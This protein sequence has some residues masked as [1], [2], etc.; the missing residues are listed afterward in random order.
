MSHVPFDSQRL[1]ELAHREYQLGHYDKAEQYCTRLW[2]NDKKNT[3]VLLL[4]SSI[5]FQC[6]RLDQSERFCQIAISENPGLAEAYSNLGNVLREKGRLSEALDKYRRAVHLKRDFIDGYINLASA[7]VQAQDIDGAIRAYLNAL[8][9][10]P[11]L[12]CVRNDLGNLLKNIGQLEEAKACYLKAIET[13]PTFAVAWSNLGCVFNCQ[14]EVW[15]AIH[16]FEKAV[17]L[18][19]TF[20]DAYVNLANVLKEAKIYDRAVTNYLRALQLAPTNAIIHANLACVYYEQQLLDL[21]VETYRRAIEI[22]P[23]F[24]DAYC[25]LANALKGLGKVQEA[26]EC[27]NKALELKPEHADSLNNLA[28]IKR[29][30]GQIDESMRLYWK[31]LEVY[32]DFAAAHSNLASVLQTQGRLQEAIKHY[33]DAIRIQ[34]TFADAFS[35]MGNALKEMGEVHGAMNCY[36]RA[37]HLNPAFA[38]AHSNLASIHKDSGNVTEAIQSYRTALRLRTDFPDAYCNLVHCQ[39]IIC[40]WTDY[41]ARMNKIVTTVQDQLDKGRIPSVH[42]HH[43]ML[44]PLTHTQRRLLSGKHAQLC[45]E[46]VMMLKHQTFSYEKALEFSPKKNFRLK[47]GLVS[48]DFCNHPTSHL[49]QSIPG[50]FDRRYFEVFCY[51]L[52]A[53]DGTTFRAKIEKEVENYVDLN[54][55]SCN[56]KA[57]NRIHEDGIHVLLNMNGY[58]KGARNEI[59]ALKPAPIQIMWLGYP[60][61]SGASY[62]DYIILDRT[63]APLEYVKQY[64]EKLAYM[65][66]TFFIGDH[67]QMFHHLRNKLSLSRPEDVEQAQ[68]S[69]ESYIRDNVAVYNHPD[70]D[71]LIPKVKSAI[72][73]EQETVS[74]NGENVKVPFYFLPLTPLD[75]IHGQLQVIQETAVQQQQQTMAQLNAQVQ[76]QTS[77]PQLQQQLIQQQQQCQPM[78]MHQIIL[79]ADLPGVHNGTTIMHTSPKH[80]TGEI[81]PN[82]GIITTRKQYELPENAIVFANFNQL[83]KLDPPTMKL[84]CRIILDVPNSVLWLLKFP[85]AGEPNLIQFAQKMGVELN[86]IIF[87][88]VASKEEHVRRGQLADVCLDSPLC[89]GHT[90]SM[91]MLWA[92]TPVITLPLETLASRVAA[93]QLMALGC[94]EL[95]AKD[96]DDFVRIAA[97]LGTDLNYLQKTRAKVWHAR[98]H[99]PLF[100]CSLY[101]RD[102][103]QLAKRAWDT[104]EVDTTKENMIHITDIESL[105]KEECEEAKNGS[106]VGGKSLKQLADEAQQAAAEFKMKKDQQDQTQLTQFDNIS[107]S[108]KIINSFQQSPK[109]EQQQQYE[110]P[111]APINGTNDG[112]NMMK[113]DQQNLPQQQQQQQQ[114][115]HLNGNGPSNNN[116]NNANNG[117]REIKQEL[118]M[119]NG[120]RETCEERESLDSIFHL[121]L[122]SSNLLSNISNEH[123]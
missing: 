22:Q 42:P 46:R 81:T 99:S 75:T 73:I 7:L 116:N 71:E 98:I 45:T 70:F 65:P 27:Y 58:T 79:D 44:Y 103:E 17:H 107:K 6:G 63:T 25:N 41:D 14:G 66:H 36:L 56:G 37:I 84:W 121:R 40:D 97:K 13:N 54:Q 26:E 23:N 32:P 62:M 83:Y 122:F 100:D 2:A 93:S 33:R 106:I 74:W 8:H 111:L 10:N 3:N 76:Q 4:M 91:D 20:F 18:D 87:S 67:A 39:Q 114:Q 53:H 61:T 43:S 72:K 101:T 115:Q 118:E 49:M 64:S 104:Y 89:N 29:E 55:I 52:S 9:Y 108:L 82:F 102:L 94:P 35:N 96:E 28:N 68:H 57:V 50:M 1:T 16:H 80:A 109:Q 85:P 5:H 21:A 105:S 86:R 90:T 78:T 19:S 112:S 113:H 123:F 59:F 51:G 95:I 117:L 119:L 110:M 60:G 38:D 34:P 92:G 30:Q 48:S 69:P 15:L 31:A 47:I 24:P 77:N 12:F 88:N 120:K 11:E